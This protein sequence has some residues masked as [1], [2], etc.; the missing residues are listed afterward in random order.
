VSDEQ[1]LLA[2]ICDCPEDDVPRL[3][4]ADWLEE[5]GPTETNRARSELIRLQCD[6]ARLPA[7][8]ADIVAAERRT[9]LELRADDLLRT[10]GHGAPWRQPLTAVPSTV[11]F[12]QMTCGPFVRGFPSFALATPDVFA[13]LGEDLFRMN[14]LHV[15]WCGVSD[16]H[17]LTPQRA[18]RLLTA[19]WLR[20]ARRME[21]SVTTGVVEPLFRCENLAGLERLT[22][23]RA[24]LRPPAS[25]SPGE[26]LT[27]LRKLHLRGI[28]EGGP[29]VVARLSGLLSSAQLTELT[30]GVGRRAPVETIRALAVFAPFG[31][32]ERLGLFAPDRDQP[33]D[34]AAIRHLTAAPFWPNLR[35]L[36]ISSGDETME[37]LAEVG[38]SSNLQVLGLGVHSLTLRGIAALAR[39]PLLRSVT[40]LD[41]ACGNGIGDEGIA[42]L[43]QSPHLGNLVELDLAYARLGPKGVKAL[44]AAPWARN[45]VRLNLRDNAIRKA[46][47]EL[48]ASPERFP[49]LLRLD[50]Q[51]AVATNKLKAVLAD[52]F[53]SGVRFTF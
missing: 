25:P 40:S 28:P 43:A 49:R 34:A 48:L 44:A 8:D 50:L 1:G 31:R 29:D 41:L 10:N 20:R 4:Y 5:H 6:S 2:A 45:L 21:V 17:L 35:H 32:L 12:A 14:P 46:G 24:D 19:P 51:R 27:R 3:V 39:A 47:V 53:G 11:N 26:G 23:H 36:R 52:R 22:I 16:E 9:R 13:S 42:L 37:A 33:F 18:D 7:E 30:L 38:P 15:V